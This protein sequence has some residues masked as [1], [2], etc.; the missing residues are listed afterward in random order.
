MELLHLLELVA[1]LPSNT[2]FNYVRSADECKF[3]NVDVQAQRINAVAPNGDDKSWAPSYLEDLAPKI[4]ENE[5]F[6]LSGLL[7][8][9]GSYRPVLETI[10]AH[11]REFYWVKKGTAVSL[12]WIPTKPKGALAL[13]EISPDEIPAPKLY[14]PRNITL[15][16]EEIRERMF[17]NFIK[18]FSTYLRL[19]TGKCDDSKLQQ[20]ISLYKKQIEAPLKDKFSAFNSIFE[21]D[22]LFSLNEFIEDAV[23]EIPSLEI[24]LSEKWP[25]EKEKQS[26]YYEPWTFFRH[27]RAF[28]DLFNSIAPLAVSLHS[29]S[30]IIKSHKSDSS[31]TGKENFLR[32]MRTK[33]FLLLA[34]ISGTGKS[35]IVK[36]FAFKSCPDVAALRK[37]PTSPGNYCLVEVKPNWH[38]STEL[39]GYESQIGGAHF[40]LTPFVKFVAKAM[41]NSDVP[42]FVCLDEM[43]LAP[44][45]QYFAE[46]LSVLESRKLID[47]HITS[48]PLIKAD[49]FSNNEYKLKLQDD[50]FGLEIKE[51]TTDGGRHR[52][53]SGQLSEEAKE[54]YKRLEKEGLRIPENLIVIGTVNMDETTHQFSRK[55]IDRAMT[56][57]MNIED[58]KE[59]FNS[60]FEDYEELA[61][62]DNPLP[63]ELFLPRFVAAAEAL[64]DMDEAVVENLKLSVPERLAALNAALNGTPFKI[65]YRVQN[66]L[67]LYFAALLAETPD[68]DVET[69]LNTAV[70]N[71]MM[72]KVLPRIEGD[73]DTLKE[74]LKKL[75][76]FTANVYPQSSDKVKEMVERLERAHFTSFWP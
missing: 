64:A 23:T 18:Y 38:D 33:P 10:I 36:Q 41:L 65:A 7:N 53:I 56:I 52:I 71:I 74:P 1:E 25:T 58:G 27:Y 51:E 14:Q 17:N 16:K 13:E 45:E 28:L 44:V 22:S 73:E 60:F 76:E 31:I 40:V 43:N 4:L 5:P 50:L 72:M 69:L 3:I 66:E 62:T 42:F 49:I 32:A 34:G 20:Y 29:P 11:T 47:G 61:Y 39:L 30:A 2:T 35:R 21:Y 8:N 67:I 55:V 15:S 26:I 12:V 48:E 37:D 75:A 59:P 63:K 70:D 6:N 46:F 54:I 19:S 57:E 24:L 68:A 9:K